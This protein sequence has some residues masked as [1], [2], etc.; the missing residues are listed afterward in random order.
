MNQHI[1]LML[2][3]IS[4]ILVICI[5][6]ITKYWALSFCMHERVLHQLLS[7]EVYFNRGISW[8]MFHSEDSLFFFL[9][10]IIICLVIVFFIAYIYR[11]YQAQQPLFGAAL[12]LGGALSNLLDRL[13][14]GAVVDFIVVH[15]GSW[16]FPVFNGADLAICV[17]ILL[18]IFTVDL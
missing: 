3:I 14:H 8:S 4:A 16:N 11:L 13:L 10:S 5:D 17:G 12:V 6:Q 15:I 18:M 2:G 7:C 9:I 1:R